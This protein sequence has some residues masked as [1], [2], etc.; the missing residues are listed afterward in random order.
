[1]A[2]GE[3]DGLLERAH[4]HGIGSDARTAAPWGPVTR[5]RS[6]S[7]P[8][9]P[10]PETDSR[11]RSACSCARAAPREG[12][13]RAPRPSSPGSGRRAAAWAASGPAPPGDGR[14][15]SLHR[16]LVRGIHLHAI[17]HHA[18]DLEALRA[19]PAARARPRRTRRGWPRSPRARTAAQ[20]PVALAL[21]RLDPRARP[22]RG[23]GPPP[24]GR[25]L[26][27]LRH[28]LREG[29]LRRSPRARASSRRRGHALALALQLLA[30]GGELQEVGRGALGAAGDRLARVLQRGQRPS[31]ST[32]DLPR[33]LLAGLGP[34]L[35]RA[36]SCT[37]ASAP[38][39]SCS[40]R[41]APRGAGPLPRGARD[42]A[43]Q[44]AR[45]ATPARPP[46][47]RLGGARLRLAI[48]SR[49]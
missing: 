3:A 10:S 42:V 14:R 38:A 18:Q 7:S 41:R 49:Q 31:R 17:G 34:G 9:A 35:P 37:A 4:D 23:P 6:L 8:T 28:Q 48:C 11:R 21:E 12:T 39:A 33:R 26:V 27:A 46:P 15:G 30:L 36:A 45:R 40:A 44:R 2:L 1:V 47:A 24:R 13:S 29:R 22:R 43:G 25:G 32:C 19:A 20:Q 5:M 16:A